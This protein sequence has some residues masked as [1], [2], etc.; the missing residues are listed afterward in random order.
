MW[1]C[2]PSLLGS[3]TSGTPLSVLMD[4]QPWS[5]ICFAR[6][7]RSAGASESSSAQGLSERVNGNESDLLVAQS[8]V[9]VSLPR[10]S[11]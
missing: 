2:S 9:N 3:R 1:S 4:V 10:G 5:R 8:R 6:S 11:V 7:E